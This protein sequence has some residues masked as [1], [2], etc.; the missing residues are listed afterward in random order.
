MVWIHGEN[1]GGLFGEE[2][3]R[4]QCERCKVEGKAINRMD[5][6][7]EKNAKWKECL[8]SKEG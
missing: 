4:M 8:W 7:C 5:G 1:G 6:W 2:N 3:S